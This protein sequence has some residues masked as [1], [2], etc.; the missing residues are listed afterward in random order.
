VTEWL[1]RVFPIHGKRFTIE[2]VANEQ[3]DGCLLTTL[4]LVVFDTDGKIR[5]V[6]EQEVYFLTERRQT[7]RGIEF[8]ERLAARI[9]VMDPD[10]LDVMMPHDLFSGTALIDTELSLDAMMRALDDPR[11]C[12]ILEVEAHARID[13]YRVVPPV[14]CNPE[15]EDRIVAGEDAYAVYGDWL[16]ERGDP[17]GELIA[18]AL[19]REVA[20]D[21][22]LRAREQ[23]LLDEYAFE[24][25]GQLAWAP[26]DEATVRWRRGF[27]RA[28]R[29]GVESV[30]NALGSIPAAYDVRELARLPGMRF[31]EEVELGRKEI[32]DEDVF[33]AI[34]EVGLHARALSIRTPELSEAGNVEPAYPGL[35]T[36]R[37]LRIESRAF[38]L[39]AIDLPALRSLELV[40][41]GLTRDNLASVL[42]ANCPDLERLVLWLGEVGLH[43]CDVELADLDAL[44]ATDRFPKLRE[45]G[46][47]GGNIPAVLE[48]TIGTPLLA[49]LKVLDAAGGYLDG[50]D[51]YWVMQHASA[52]AHLE[53]LRL[54]TG[55]SA[56]NQA[57]EELEVRVIQDER[58]IPVYE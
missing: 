58:Y 31:V 14:L 57:L 16:A 2:L 9:Q 40:T 28:V 15:L 26:V 49:R 54:P 6:K 25:L 32:W 5:D 23:A 30:G 48:R 1:Q 41:R 24:W 22:T 3:R 55:N 56:D 37:E 33:V 44:L 39:G 17:R 19:A 50:T 51:V 38:E 45:L 18:I 20:D 12:R 42:A 8:I 46:L 36:L 21:E 11:S 13:P 47:C 43:D 53:A 34:G 10:T 35:A 7:P 52:F 27:V 29:S 4:R